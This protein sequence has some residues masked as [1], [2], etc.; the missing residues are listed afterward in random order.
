MIFIVSEIP[1]VIDIYDRIIA[2]C[3]GE[4]TGGFGD[5]E[6]NKEKLI[7]AATNF[8]KTQD[9]CFSSGNNLVTK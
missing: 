6:I 9:R 3:E 1:E 5:K 8:K 7:K 4:I 2:M